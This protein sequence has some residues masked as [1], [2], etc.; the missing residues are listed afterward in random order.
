MVT[1]KETVCHAI[2][3]KL[4]SH[5]TLVPHKKTQ[6]KKRRITFNFGTILLSTFFTRPA[7]SFSRKATEHQASKAWNNRT[8]FTHR[9][10]GL[11]L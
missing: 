3:V 5:Y 9:P 11:S 7:S 6:I 2:R 10:W 8:T 1:E 4:S